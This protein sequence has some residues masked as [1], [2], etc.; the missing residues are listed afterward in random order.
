MASSSR[1][2][3]NALYEQLARVGKALA[4]P[5]RLELIEL[6]S[7]GPRTVE[8][9]AQE[10][11]MG[12][13][14]TS[15]HLQVLRAGGLVKSQKEGLYVTYRLAD[16]AVA[17]LFAEFRGLAET[18]LAEVKRLSHDYFQSRGALEPIS[19]DTLLERARAGDVVVLD[20]RPAEEYAA[21]HLPKALSIP[22]QELEHRLAELP[23]DKTIVA[24]CRGP[25][26]VFAVD[27][28]TLLK[29]HGFSAVRLE[30]GVADWR[31]QGLT[32]ERIES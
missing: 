7:Q 30:D 11:A 16:D 32:I 26:C 22:I 4:N 20:V 12:L 5:H 2:F 3:K 23:R 9:L 25:Y 31:A 13:P 29:Q 21:G 15:Q 10:T 17:T 6:L 18:Q 24:Y 28:V 14:S 8:A 19:R 1:Q 27:A